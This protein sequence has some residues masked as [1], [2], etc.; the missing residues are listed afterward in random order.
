MDLSDFF[1]SE[2]ALRIAV[3]AIPFIFSLIYLL[4]KNYKE[5]KDRKRD[6]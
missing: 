4:A 5:S 2:F 1:E 6:S 3:I